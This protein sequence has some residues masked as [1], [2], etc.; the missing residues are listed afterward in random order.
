MATHRFATVSAIFWISVFASFALAVPVQV[1]EKH[2]DFINGVTAGA[3]YRISSFTVQP[4]GLEGEL[5]CLSSTPDP[6]LI[7]SLKLV[8]VYQTESRLRFKIYDPNTPRFEVPG[9]V[10]EDLESF[11]KSQLKF[12]PGYSVRLSIEPF[13][14]RVTRTD[15]S[16]MFDSSP[17]DAHPTDLVFTDRYIEFG[18]TLDEDSNIY[19]LGERI[20][21]FRRDSNTYTLFNRDQAAS[22]DLINLY[23]SQ[24]F[25]LD[26]RPSK[27]AAHGVFLLN[28]NAMDVIIVNSTLTYKT[29]GGILDFSIVVGPEPETAIKQYHEVVGRPYFIP[30]WV[31]GFHQCRWGYRNLDQI[32][33][34]VAGYEDAGI[35]LDTMWF[36]IDY[37]DEKKLWTFDPVNYP[38]KDVGEFVDY[39]HNTGRR[40]VPIIDPGVF[41]GAG[42]EPYEDGV[43][44]DVFIKHPTEEKPFL[45]IVWPG[46]THFPDWTHPNTPAYWERW[47]KVFYEKAQYDGLWNDMNEL[48]SFCHGRCELQLDDPSTWEGCTEC[49]NPVVYP[50]DRPPYIPGKEFLD[51][52]S[53]TMAARY[54]DGLEYDYHNINAMLQARVTHVAFRNILKDKRPFLLTR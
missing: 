7:C 45:G 38:E 31:L 29:V 51:W 27:A 24:P 42:Y 41:A 47:M 18:T 3:N 33:G 43:Q 19:G 22:P 44:N 9:V 10:E 8:V 12:T 25:Y 4:W 5:D 54:H 39:L 26:W 50:E 16:V 23:G 21:S 34:V 30:Y 37:M 52:R 46:P 11:K 48:V 20:H 28:S 1:I 35:P 6:N 14:I 36:D 53:L 49:E 40:M 32:K 17:S 13:S 2:P 15:G